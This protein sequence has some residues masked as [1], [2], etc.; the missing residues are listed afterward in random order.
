MS[1]GSMTPFYYVPVQAS[2][3]MRLLKPSNSVTS[4]PLS[5]LTFSGELAMAF[6]SSMFILLPTPTAYTMIP[7][8]LRAMADGMVKDWLTLERPSVITTA[9][10]G[11]ATSADLAPA[12][13]TKTSLLRRIKPSAVLVLV[14]PP[15]PVSTVNNNSNIH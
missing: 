11:M 4:K 2:A 1:S 3:V 7:S 5:N 15:L 6:N 13:G 9:T 10:R 14:L 12:S 8:S